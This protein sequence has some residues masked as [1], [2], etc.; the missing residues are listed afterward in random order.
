L[1]KL[2]KK[3]GKQLK[4][5]ENM[6]TINELFKNLNDTELT[7]II[8]E[9]NECEKTG[10]F[11]DESEIR[12]LCRKTSEI[13]GMDISSNLLMVQMGVLKE[14]AFRWLEKIKN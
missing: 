13:T 2:L 12:K 1:Q 7:I 5:E 8:G 9:I 10:T 11:G 3:L 4:H 14:A 6:K